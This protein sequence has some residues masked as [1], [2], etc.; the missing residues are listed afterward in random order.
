MIE[1]GNA[2]AGQFCWVDLAAS[3][4]DAAKTFYG[5]M[6]GWTSSEQPASGG[7]FTRLHQSG[8]DVGSLYQLSQGHLGNGVPS[9]WTP[10]IRVEDVEAAAHRAVA[11]GGEIIVPPFE[12]PGTARIALV[13]DCVG[14]HFGLWQPIGSSGGEGAGD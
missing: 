9:H 14:A 11:L 1:L 8:Q 12:V 6:F 2:E 3:D 10:Y 4:A 7:C 5:Q 13:L